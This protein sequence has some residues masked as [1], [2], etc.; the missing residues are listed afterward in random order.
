MRF[1]DQFW[2]I[3]S[4]SKYKQIHLNHQHPDQAVSQ[5]EW[6][7][8]CLCPDARIV[9]TKCHMNW[10]AFQKKKKPQTYNVP[11]IYICIGV[12]LDP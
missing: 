8:F 7:N 1:L 6:M 2:W 11:R 9:Q 5:D 4:F 3:F 10:Q 12:P